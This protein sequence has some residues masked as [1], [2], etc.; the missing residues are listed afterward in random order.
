MGNGEKRICRTDV[1]I[2]FSVLD[3]FGPVLIF[4]VVR[5]I[6]VVLVG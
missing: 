2:T 3:V 1:I 4:F 6:A 5:V